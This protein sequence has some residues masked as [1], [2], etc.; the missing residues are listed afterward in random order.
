MVGVWV[1]N[2]DGEGRLG[3]TGSTAAAPILFD[4]VRILPDAQYSP[5]E[6]LYPYP[7][8]EIFIP[9]NAS[10]EKEKIVAEAAHV[11]PT[12]SVFWF[13]DEYYLGTTKG[14]H[15]MALQPSVGSHRISLTD[16]EGNQVSRVFVIL[17]PPVLPLLPCPNLFCKK[18]ILQET[19][20]RLTAK[21]Q[22]EFS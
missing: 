21:R 11:N 1:G 17:S 3:L 7:G 22:V 8:E 12:L 15:K 9:L 16:T 4:L 13:L 6:I 19:T 18:K 10:G 2:G 5:I 14:I 20:K